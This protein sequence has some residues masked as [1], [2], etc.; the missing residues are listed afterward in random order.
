MKTI[1]YLILFFFCLSVDIFAVGPGGPDQTIC[2]N[3]STIMAATGSGIWSVL[4]GNPATVTIFSPSSAITQI[5][6]FTTAGVYGFIWTSGVLD[7][8]FI[9]A[10]SPSPVSVSIS[11]TNYP[12][13]FAPDTFAATPVNGGS[14]PSYQWFLNGSPTGSN[15]PKFV[16]GLG[17]NSTIS[18]TLTSS[19]SCISGNPAGN[20]LSI[21]LGYGPSAP[22][23]A[24]NGNHCA[25]ADS[26]SIVGLPMETPGTI[27][28]QG[29]TPVF[30]DTM[31]APTTAAGNGTAGTAA[32]QVSSPSGLCFDTAGYLYVIDGAN[33]RV[34]KFPPGST[35]LTNGVTVAGGNGRGMAFNQFYNPFAIFVDRHN[36]L[37]VA[38]N[39]RVLKFP[40][41]STS[42]TLGTVAA[43]NNGGG[44][45]TWQLHRPMGIFVD[46]SGNLYVADTYEARVLKF[47]PG[48]TSSTHGQVVAGY[49]SQFAN[50]GVDG[51]S[52]PSGIIVDRAGYLY[53]ADAGNNRI[54]KFPPNSVAHT[55]GTTIIGNVNTY[56]YITASD[57]V[58]LAIDNDGYIY[59]CNQT[60]YSVRRFPPYTAADTEGVMVA[61]IYGHGNGAYQ[62]GLPYGVKLDAAGN[63][64]VADYD[65]N[66]VQKCPQKRDL[67][68]YLPTAPGSYSVVYQADPTQ[69]QCATSDG[70]AIVTVNASGAA[71][72][73][74]SA[75]QT[76]ICSGVPDTFRAVP[77]IG[78]TVPTY[79]W[80]KNGAAVGTNSAIFIS[81]ALA[82]GDSIWVRMTSNSACASPNTALSNKIYLMSN[83]V[84]PSV[85]ITASQTS[86]CSGSTDTF[87]AAT[88]NGG[89]APVY[90]WYK[91]SVLVSSGSTIFISSTLG[92]NDTI[93]F[94][95]TNNS[96]CATI[97]TVRSNKV[98]VA[99]SANVT[100]SVSI[101]A[102]GLIIHAG[103]QDT[104]QATA[105]NGGASPGFQWYKNGSPSGTNSPTFIASSLT[106]GDSIWVAMTSGALCSAPSVVF[107]NHIIITVIAPAD[108]VWPGDGDHNGTVD[109]NDLLPIGLGYDTAGPVRNIQGIVWHGYAAADWTDTFATYSPVVNFKHADCNGDGQINAT[110]TLAITQNYS[111]A[112]AKS[113]ESFPWRTGIPVLTP[114]NS[115][116]SLHGGDM[117]NVSFILGD[118][119][120]PMSNF[121]GLAFTY[122]YDATLFD[123][124][125]TTF[126]YGNSWI[127]S[128]DKISIRRVLSYNG[129]IQTAVTRIDHTNRSGNGSIAT[130]TFKVST[131]TVPLSDAIGF[132]TDVKAVDAAGHIIPL[133]AGADTSQ[134][135]NIGTGVI[136]QAE[137][138]ISVKPNP[139]YDKITI[140]A[141]GV[142]QQ[143]YITNMIGQVMIDNKSDKQ[144]EVIDVSALNAG[145][146]MVHVKTMNKTIIAKFVVEK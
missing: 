16:T 37:Y 67:R 103:S 111:L 109:N 102:S 106:D 71:S 6:G 48:S 107:S 46:S 142:I 12:C 63:V 8:V 123:S 33:Y 92:N 65:N 25:G 5:S 105:V 93:E 20:S 141:G 19:Q 99:I 115:T 145:I 126:S 80:Y 95:L 11:G 38:D 44:D 27:W 13:A 112:H 18:V 81:N 17:S 2:R 130:A 1:F 90:E 122:N 28:Y 41:G 143:I 24:A 62:L 86:L 21:T 135:S 100:P 124:S 60:E 69:Y 61:G 55:P 40:A 91:N 119:T 22:L 78:G 82:G 34:L 76:S 138:S 45:S 84:T 54:Q 144:V 31:V 108:S 43:G 30:Y 68:H 128:S 127:G 137:E 57:P 113:N 114:V 56:N 35:S 98:I 79:Q 96:A 89:A 110:D 59:V 120:L 132:I 101:T 50:S 9:T 23:L 74:I 36:D 129:Q 49:T 146:Y 73:T 26:L 140:N 83:A 72:V 88:V 117:L 104:L 121:Y 116:D 133:N 136:T 85:T 70:A 87:S 4:P 15:S 47:P 29:S 14:S 97:N 77:V 53:V 118:A 39:E 10:S 7:T 75:S 51:L 32:N 42:A 66:R 125:Y 94:R 134:V 58:D 139:A 52:Y 64:Y 3:T 131:H